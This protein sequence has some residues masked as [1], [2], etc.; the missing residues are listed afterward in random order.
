M[1]RH[2]N[3]L[4]REVL[5]APSLELF[6]TTLDEALGSLIYG[7]RLELGDLRSL[8]T[9]PNPSHAST[10]CLIF[11]K[12][13]A[14]VLTNTPQQCQQRQGRGMGLKALTVTEQQLRTT[15][16]P[17]HPLHHLL[18]SP[19]PLRPDPS[20]S[21]RAPRARGSPQLPAPAARPRLRVPTAAKRGERP[22]G[23]RT[24]QPQRGP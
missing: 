23:A 4:A 7:T 13:S 6:K 12:K 10:K 21:R 17:H 24:W 2:W 20:P 19:E 11:H 9:Q 15:T 16:S 18:P 3:R 22:R 1:L 8:P 5:D 14:R